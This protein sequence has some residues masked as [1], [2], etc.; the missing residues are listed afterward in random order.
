M[1]IQKSKGAGVGQQ[2]AKQLSNIGMG[3]GEFAQSQTM[4]KKK[5]KK[6][7]PTPL[8]QRPTYNI[9]DSNNFFDR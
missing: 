3:A 2:I 6:R 1:K 7:N 9:L 4:T 8:A 5:R